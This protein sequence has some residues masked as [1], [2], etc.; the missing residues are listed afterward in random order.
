MTCTVGCALPSTKVAQTNVGL[1]VTIRLHITTVAQVTK[2]EQRL[3][4]FSAAQP[5]LKIK[6]TDLFLYE[7]AAKYKLAQKMH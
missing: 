4:S 1:P 6:S 2:G 7:Q 3:K 5:K